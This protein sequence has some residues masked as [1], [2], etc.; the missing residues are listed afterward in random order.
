MNSFYNSYSIDI[1]IEEIKLPPFDEILILGKKS[2]HG[3]MG[4]LK[5][6]ELLAPNG[7]ELVE[8]DHEFVQAVFINRRIIKKIS[9][10]SVLKILE[11][12]V[13]PYISEGELL[14]VDLKITIIQNFIQ[15]GV[16]SKP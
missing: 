5:S 16:D 13:F 14:K 10:E 8:V 2:H 3:K 1:R 12:R 15:R 9:R 7:F 6:F 11:E 4:I